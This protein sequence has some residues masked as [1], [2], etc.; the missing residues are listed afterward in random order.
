MNIKD[1]SYSRL[2]NNLQGAN[3]PSDIRG[4]WYLICEYQLC[5]LYRRKSRLS[6][7]LGAN[8][9]VQTNIFPV[10]YIYVCRL[11]VLYVYSYACSVYL[12]LFA[13]CVF[14]GLAAWNKMDDDD[15]DD[16]DDAWW[17]QS[18]TAAIIIRPIATDVAWT[19]SVS[20]GHNHDL[21]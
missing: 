10:Y 11:S 7:T 2:C 17:T 12:C 3:G 13:C 5:T 18:T 8:S 20:V 4:R 16:D 14:M 19:V 1:F 9:P 15:D 21:C 6:D